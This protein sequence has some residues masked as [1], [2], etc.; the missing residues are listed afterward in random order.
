MRSGATKTQ[1]A[2]GGA[3][4]QDISDAAKAVLRNPVPNSGTTDRL[5]QGAALGGF[6][7]DPLSTT[8]ALAAAGA[9]S[10]PYRYPAMAAALL[11]GG[12]PSAATRQALAG[13]VQ[14]AGAPVAGSLLR[15]DEEE[16]LR[17]ALM[18]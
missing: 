9:A 2:A 11:R 6:L 18:R 13:S 14:Q 17:A 1:R 15:A 10:L 5:L 3:P 16:R 7:A 4:L 12:R 8:G